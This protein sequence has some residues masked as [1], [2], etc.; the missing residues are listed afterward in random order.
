[1]TL[2][3]NSFLRQIFFLAQ[4]IN[5]IIVGICRFWDWN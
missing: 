1:M 3:P 2:V 5:D 4:V